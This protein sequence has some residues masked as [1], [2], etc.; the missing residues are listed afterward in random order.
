MIDLH[1][2]IR[3]PLFQ[4]NLILWCLIES[5]YHDAQINIEPVMRSWGY[6]L[7]SLE[8]KIALP[9]YPGYEGAIYPLIKRKLSSPVPDLWLEH[10]DDQFDLIIEL[11][12]RSFGPDSDK[13]VQ[14][15]KIISASADLSLSLGGGPVRLGHVIV[16][17]A[18]EDMT[19]MAVTLDALRGKLQERHIRSA[20]IGVIGLLASDDKVALVSPEPNQLPP[21]LRNQFNNPVVVLQRDGDDEIV[22]TYIIPWIPGIKSAQNYLVAQDGLRELTSRLLT[23]VSAVIGQVNIPTILTIKGE[24]LLDDATLTTFRYWK[25]GAKTEFVRKA[26]SI[27]KRAINQGRLIKRSTS[28]EIELIDEQQRQ[29]ILRRIERFR[30]DD[31]ETNLSQATEPTLFDELLE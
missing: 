19:S 14:M 23:H 13:A 18:A 1:S 15:M 30:T 17:T 26:I 4:L 28:L 3:D 10:K 25:D 24:S 12:A 8:N 29:G 21:P 6:K 22:P 9:S 11:K 2:L 16:V 7:Y 27:V 31:V 20:P 5:P